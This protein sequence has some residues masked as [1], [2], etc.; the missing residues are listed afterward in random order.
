MKKCAFLNKESLLIHTTSGN[1]R[2]ISYY[3]NIVVLIQVE[4]IDWSDPRWAWLVA[5]FTEHIHRKNGVRFAWGDN[6]REK[7]RERAVCVP[8]ILFSPARRRSLHITLGYE[9]HWQSKWLVSHAI[10][11][12]TECVCSTDNSLLPTGLQQ[13]AKTLGQT[14]MLREHC[15]HSAIH[16]HTYR[17]CITGGYVDCISWTLFLGNIIEQMNLNEATLR[18]SSN[19]V[20][21]GKFS[22]YIRR[23]PLSESLWNCYLNWELRTLCLF[24]QNVSFGKQCFVSQ[25]LVRLLDWASLI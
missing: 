17:T 18:R 19:K 22:D 9:N 2:R 20:K 25:S 8:L 24:N 11:I 21:H 16:K 10:A 6:K 4:A 3:W 5:K 12:A 1:G 7:E 14:W 13:V 23:E 15:L